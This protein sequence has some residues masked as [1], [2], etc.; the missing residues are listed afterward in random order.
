MISIAQVTRN[1]TMH[2]WSD[3]RGIKIAPS[4][5]NNDMYIFSIQRSDRYEEALTGLTAQEAEMLYQQYLY[6]LTEDRKVFYLVKPAIIAG[7]PI[8]STSAPTETLIAVD[9]A[10]ANNVIPTQT[11]SAPV[12]RKPTPRKV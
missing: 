1:N 9:G 3:V 7:E 11:K 6:T 2:V 10:S 8:I 12:R 4:V 5:R